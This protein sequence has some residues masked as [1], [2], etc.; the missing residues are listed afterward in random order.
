MY[1][2][3]SMQLFPAIS[4]HSNQSNGYGI[5]QGFTVAINLDTQTMILKQLLSISANQCCKPINLQVIYIMMSP[6]L[7]YI[8]YTTTM[9][10]FSD[11]KAEGELKIS[12]RSM[13]LSYQGGVYSSYNWFVPWLECTTGL[14]CD[15]VNMRLHGIISMHLMNRATPECWVELMRYYKFTHLQLVVPGFD[16][17]GSIVYINIKGTTK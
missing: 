12:L 8:G 13:K 6:R 1:I 17:N 10:Q 4:Y 15:E 7:Y 14:P 3:Q 16:L 5:F 11:L 2:S 9:R